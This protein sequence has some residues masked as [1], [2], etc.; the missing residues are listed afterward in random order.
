MVSQSQVAVEPTS[1]RARQRPGIVL[2]VLCASGFM[3]GLDVFIVNVALDDIGHDFPGASLAD[4]SWIL[5]AYAIAYA[6][7]LVPLG[8]LADRYGAKRGFLLG[9]TVFTS[10]SAACAASPSLWALILFRGLQAVG[11]AALTPASLGLLLAAT[12]PERRTRAVRIW[13]ASGA[14]AAA[15]G[16]GLGGLLVQSSWRWIFLV[17]VPVGVLALVAGAR[18]LPD[19]RKTVT[20]RIPDAF[21]GLVLALSIGSLSL[22]LVKGPAWGWASPATV[23]CLLLAAAGAAV[24]THRTARHPAPL[25]EPA[26]LRVKAFAWSNATAL[27]FSVAF[28]ANLLAIVL[29]TQQ[30]WHYSA[31]RTGLAVAP[32]PLMVPLFAALAHYMTRRV[33]AGV[34]ATVG[35]LLYGL[36]AALLALRIETHPHYAADLLPSMLI[37]GAGVGLTMPTI[38][39]CATADLRPTQG[40]TGSAMVNMSQQIGNSLGIAALVATLAATTASGDAARPSPHGWWLVSGAALF[41]ALCALGMT[42]RGKTVDVTVVE[43]PA[44]A[45]SAAP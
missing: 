13:S 1:S 16:P 21:G 36:A 28:G 39:A 43:E 7:L 45:G 26:L 38:L 5:N 35:S 22:A 20:G 17:N 32:G 3:A 23:E 41:A 37:S 34:I 10:A 44:R 11:A 12:A 30:V 9:L 15:A 6:A 42:P 8:S 25:V 4:M 14:L 33:P 24:F 18:V 31:V 27:L 2:T 19:V 40:A 29:W